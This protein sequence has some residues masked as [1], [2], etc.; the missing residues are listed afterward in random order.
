ME[1]YPKIKISSSEKKWS[2][3]ILRLKRNDENVGEIEV[4]KINEV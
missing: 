1:K 2:M 4:E 3:D